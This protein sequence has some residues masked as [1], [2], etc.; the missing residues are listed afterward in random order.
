MTTKKTIGAPPYTNHRESL[1]GIHEHLIIRSEGS[2]DENS[3]KD[4]Q[5][6]KQKYV[7]F[8]GKDVSRYPK[9]LLE[10]QTGETK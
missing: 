2:S 7:E 1:E 6:A 4:Y 5:L 9:S 3:E 8:G 10:K